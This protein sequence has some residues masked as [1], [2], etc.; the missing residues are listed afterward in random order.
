M[1]TRLFKILSGLLIAFYISTLFLS[2]AV[3]ARST[4]AKNEPKRG[5]N[6]QT[7]RLSFIGGGDPIFVAG[8]SGMKGLSVQDRAH[9][10]ANVYGKEFGLSNPSQDLKPVK[11]QKDSNGKTIVRFQQMYRD[12]PVYAGEMLVNTNGEGELLSISGEVSPDLT[13]STR[14]GMTAQQARKA[15]LA[16]VASLYQMDTKDLNVSDPELWIFDEFLLQASTRPAELVWRME[17]RAS[18]FTQPVRELVM[19]NAQTGGVSF[20]FN[21]TDGSLAQQAACTATP[22]SG[23]SYFDMAIDEAHGRIFG[24]DSGDTKL[25]VFTYSGMNPPVFLTTI[26]LGFHPRGIDIS[27]DGNELAV[28]L[29]DGGKLAFYDLTLPDEQLAAQTPQYIV[30]R[31]DAPSPNKPYDVV[32]GRTGRLYASG[33][34]NSSGY[35]YLH[36][37]DTS[38]SPK[39]ELG[40]STQVVRMAPRLAM[41]QDK[42]VLFDLEP[43]GSPIKLYRFDAST[44]TLTSSVVQ[45]PH[46]LLLGQT[47]ATI[48]DPSKIFT[49]AGQVWSTAGFG[50][51][52][53][54][55]MMGEFSDKGNEIEYVKAHDVLAVSNGAQVSLISTDE[56]QVVARL[57]STG[58]PASPGRCRM[59]WRFSSAP[60]L[61]CSGSHSNRSPSRFRSCAALGCRPPPTMTWSST[62]ST[63]GSSPPTVPAGRWTSSPSILWTGL[64]CLSRA[65]VL[66]AVSRRTWTSARMAARWRLVS[67]TVTGWPLSIPP[68]RRSRIY[69]SSCLPMDMPGPA[70]WCMAAPGGCMWAPRIRTFL[71]TAI[72]TPWMSQVSHSSPARAHAFIPFTAWLILQ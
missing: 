46:S 7:G 62:K 45:D 36:V 59:A 10:M 31:V 4:P 6:P 57:P 53:V 21:Q 3:L 11:A 47:F 71:P 17:V 22:L 23:A 13:L 2:G 64:L 72:S 65:S 14:P 15:G 43:G 25:D 27:P 69:R 61:V 38:T 19:V 30:P 70:T 67:S 52:N 48:N 51:R 63:I 8:V 29:Y 33:N 24:S 39:V 58:Q 41:S 9:G 68:P 44:D 1:K 54:F 26:C 35:D 32:Y 18:D 34:P 5:V 28:T 12:V 56:Y 40:R 50:T 37:I 66:L 20:H 16:E 55:S 60:R 42:N 49:S